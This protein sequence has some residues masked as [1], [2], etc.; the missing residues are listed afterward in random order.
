MTL[1]LMVDRV[2]LLELEDSGSYPAASK[3]IFS[4]HAYDGKVSSLRILNYLLS[5]HSNIKNPLAVLSWVITGTLENN[6][7]ALE[8]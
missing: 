1:S 3:C 4:P 5:A 8:P 7:S 2:F 6:L